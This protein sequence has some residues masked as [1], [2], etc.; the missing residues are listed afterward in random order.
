MRIP[1][2]SYAGVTATLALFVA[3]GGS[4]DAALTMSGKDIRNG[5]VTSSDL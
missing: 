5:T 3:L 2:P 4:S 1:R